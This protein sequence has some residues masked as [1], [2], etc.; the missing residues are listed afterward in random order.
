MNYEK[1]ENI[2]NSSVPQAH[3]ER[4]IL[5]CLAE[6]EH[7]IPDIL[8]IL[9]SEREIKKELITD[10][11]AELSR[12]HVYIYGRPESKTEAADPFNKPFVMSEIKK[13]Y[14]KYKDYI[15]HCFNF[16]F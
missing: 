15:S 3:K 7:V 2:V 6:D 5:E 9:Q 13:F 11:N 1:I 14:L 16:K 12:A 8:R 4:L 10:M